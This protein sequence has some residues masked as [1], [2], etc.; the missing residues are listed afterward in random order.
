MAEIVAALRN[1]N[2]AIRGSTTTM[3]IAKITNQNAESLMCAG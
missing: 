2:N 3:I 1:K